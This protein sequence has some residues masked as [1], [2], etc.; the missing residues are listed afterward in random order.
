MAMDLRKAFDTYLEINFE[1][2]WENCL[3]MNVF[4]FLFVNFMTVQEP[5]LGADL[6]EYCYPT[7]LDKSKDAFWP[8]LTLVKL[9]VL[10]YADDTVLLLKSI[11]GLH[12]ILL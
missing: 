5:K 7:L 8:Y 6:Q 2:N 4:Y 10:L 9:L 11:V 3:W 1:Q 12:K